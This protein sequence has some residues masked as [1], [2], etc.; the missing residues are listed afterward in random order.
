MVPSSIAR[1]L[2]FLP[3]VSHCNLQRRALCTLERVRKIQEVGVRFHVNTSKPAENHAGKR[4]GNHALSIYLENTSKKLN[5][6]ERKFDF[7]ALALVAGPRVCE[8]LNQTAGFPASFS[9]PVWKGPY[10]CPAIGDIYIVTSESVRLCL[11]AESQLFT[12]RRAR[13]RR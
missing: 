6:P 12:R 1:I 5:S 2:S 3:V 4:P 9:S 8:I 7:L 10:T 11:L 13:C